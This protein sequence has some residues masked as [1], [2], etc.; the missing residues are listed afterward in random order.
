MREF[1]FL[2]ILLVVLFIIV[3]PIGL[4]TRK[5]S[6]EI[7]LEKRKTCILFG[8]TNERYKDLVVEMSKE[9]QVI[10]TSRRESKFLDIYPDNKS[11]I[12]VYSDI[13]LNQTIESLFE[14]V[15]SVTGRVDLVINLAGV[16]I[17]S[18]RPICSERK[19]DD[20]HL[21]LQGAYTLD[22]PG[23]GYR[24]GSPGSEDW[25]FTNIIGPVNIY[26]Y[27]KLF[28]VGKLIFLNSD[29]KLVN[30]LYSEFIREKKIDI[31]ITSLSNLKI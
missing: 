11:I 20:I 8:A 9:Y 21:K 23:Y 3:Y 17:T 25:F 16:K 18:Y 1:V 14:K 12:W 2:L 5:T 26:S 24:R 31:E 15:I 19:H 10:V 28:K 13:R 22:Y 6:S 4:Y 7:K 30:E 27:C 29:S